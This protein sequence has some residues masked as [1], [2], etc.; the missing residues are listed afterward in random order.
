MSYLICQ[1][2]GINIFSQS[3]QWQGICLFGIRFII[4]KICRWLKINYK[5]QR[6]VK[7]LNILWTLPC[8]LFHGSYLEFTI[9]WGKPPTI[10]KK[11]KYL[12]NRCFIT[13]ENSHFQVKTKRR[14]FHASP[15]RR[16]LTAFIFSANKFYALNFYCLD[17]RVNKSLRRHQNCLPDVDHWLICLKFSQKGRK[18]DGWSMNSK[19]NQHLT[20]QGFLSPWEQNW[21]ALVSCVQVKNQ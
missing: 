12:L 2:L 13:Q 10:I 21:L 1:I 18:Y 8:P 3:V 15:W 9:Q 11:V 16:F 6:P 4:K 7:K 19:H 5:Q 17:V 14:T 20:N